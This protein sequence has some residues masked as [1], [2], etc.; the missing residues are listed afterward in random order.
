MQAV[1]QKLSNLFQPIFYRLFDLIWIYFVFNIFTVVT[2]SIELSPI[3][4]ILRILCTRDLE[5]YLRYEYEIFR[6]DHVLKLCLLF[7]F[8]TSGAIYIEFSMAQKLGMNFEQKFHTFYYVSLY[9]LTCFKDIY[10]KSG[11]VFN[12]HVF[13]YSYRSCQRVV[14]CLQ[15]NEWAEADNLVC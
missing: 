5:N 7:W 10:N 3:L 13:G 6:V 2:S 15:T 4:Y 9:Q 1:S 14:K 11:R 8:Y 12:F